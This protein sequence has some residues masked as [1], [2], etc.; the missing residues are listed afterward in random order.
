MM[1]NI[2][3]PKI[4]KFQGFFDIV[5]FEKWDVEYTPSI[6]F[7]DD[8]TLAYMMVDKI[9]SYHF[10]DSIKQTLQTS[11]FAWTAIFRKATFW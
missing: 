1:I 11:H 10:K 6:R 4:K 7:S 9:V 3:S 2:P 8:H 5:E